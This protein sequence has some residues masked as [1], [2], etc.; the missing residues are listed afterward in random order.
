MKV[1]LVTI[2]EPLPID[3][4]GE[5]RLYRAGILATMLAERGHEVVWWS[6]TFDH[7]RKQQRFSTDATVRLE[8]CGE[9]RL[10]H[11]CGYER[12]LSIWRLL[13]HAILARKFSSQA[14]EKPRPDIILCS[15]P[16]LDLPVAVTRY[17]KVNRVPVIVDVRDLWPD[18]FLDLV[19][20]WVRPSIKWVLA[21][22]WRQVREA[23]RNAFAVTGN[24]PEFVKW[25]LALALRSGTRFDRAFPHGYAASAPD[26][27][28]LEEARAF[29]ATHGVR[30]DDDTFVAC[31]FGAIGPQS[32]LDTVI[33]AA[34]LLDRRGRK[35][36]FVLCGKGDHLESLRRK[37]ADVASVLFPGWI[38]A[39]EIWTLMRISK[40]GLA[41]YRSNVGYVTN[42]P[43]KPIEYLSGG[44]PV[45][46]SLKGYLE[47]FLADHSCGL[48]YPNGDA[49][50]LV[51]VLTDLDNNRPRLAA[52]SA[53]A[54]RVFSELFDAEKVYGEM[55]TY[56]QEVVSAHSAQS[57]SPPHT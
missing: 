4:D 40:V 36:K 52:M 15:L 17:G 30:E 34:R 53:N 20:R 54:R 5:D 19:P 21:P 39:A 49:E 25:G 28:K 51:N 22:M 47:H 37:S 38:G 1:W 55:I 18:I 26:P 9:L 32:E 57:Q 48:T 12:N 3:G 46:S 13:D 42:M 33:T 6:S 10:M 16:P 14:M 50:A 27:T 8:R 24:A 11:G 45:V 41:V 2:G 31:F 44:L 23:C 35:F 29:W 7:V 43:N 56:L